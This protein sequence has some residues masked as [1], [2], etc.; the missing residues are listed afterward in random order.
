MPS[1]N[2]AY[3]DTQSAKGDGALAGGEGGNSLG[4]R[5]LRPTTILSILIKGTIEE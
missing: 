3:A 2:A 5:S 1:T 4:I